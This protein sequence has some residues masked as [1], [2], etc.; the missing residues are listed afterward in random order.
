MRTRKPGRREG[1]LRA[2][3]RL[4]TRRHLHEITLDEVARAAGV[5]K[6]TIYLYFADKDDL[7]FQVAT[8]GFDALC[9]V[10]R[11]GGPPGRPFRDGLLQVCGEIS[12]FFERRRQALRMMQ[13]EEGR[14]WW[15]RGP[16]RRRWLEHRN[17]LVEALA[18][19]LARG[20]AAGEVRA[21]RP[22]IVLAV[23]LLGMLRTRARELD[24]SLR[25]P[26]A[27]MVDLFLSGAGTAGRRRGQRR[28]S[29]AT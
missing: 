7:F 9:D 11:R 10:V 28:R 18:A 4:C 17:R 13:T 23:F 21:D 14:V 6:G 8:S 29:R 2:A 12:G 20:V 19:I 26:Q 16:L 24:D 25:I 22:A 27:Q 3:E 15:H 1:I 5:G